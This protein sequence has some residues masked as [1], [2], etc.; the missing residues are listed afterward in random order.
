ML[1]RAGFVKRYSFS[2]ALTAFSGVYLSLAMFLQVDLFEGF[3]DALSALE[4]FEADEV[5][6]IIFFV[7]LG[8]TIDM[9]RY[10]GLQ[11]RR[12]SLDQ[13][14]IQAMR[15]TMATVHDVVNNGLNN[16]HLIRLEAEKSQALSPE[17]L[18]LFEELISDT[19]A[20]LREIDQLESVA[21]RTLGEGLATLE[22]GRC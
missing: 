14:R 3:I 16:L 8:L 11:R 22:S 17:T 5:V 10:Q 1:R 13:E 15:A 12:I 20:Q 2:V 21:E 18:S 7:V 9:A 19:A 4:A 6:L